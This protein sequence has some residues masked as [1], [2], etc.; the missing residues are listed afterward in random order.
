MYG[1]LGI[2]SRLIERILWQP[3]K[4]AERDIGIRLIRPALSSTG[5]GASTGTSFENRF[6]IS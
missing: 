3:N 6:C 2:D 5:T 4:L 1:E